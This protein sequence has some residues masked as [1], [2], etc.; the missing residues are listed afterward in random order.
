MMLSKL[1][2]FVNKPTGI[3]DRG[4]KYIHRHK[5]KFIKTYKVHRKNKIYLD[6]ISRKCYDRLKVL[7]NPAASRKEYGMKSRLMMMC[8]MDMAMCMSMFCRAGNAPH[9]AA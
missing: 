2:L 9:T 8:M 5:R 7:K 4:D 3:F 6:T 1:F